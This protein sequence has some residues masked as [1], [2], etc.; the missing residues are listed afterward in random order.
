M[1]HMANWWWQKGMET[2]R[3]LWSSPT[4]IG[5]P[6][7]GRFKRTDLRNVKSNSINWPHQYLNFESSSIWSWW[8]QFG[9]SQSTMNC[10]SIC[11]SGVVQLQPNLL[12]QDDVKDYSAG[13]TR[14]ECS[15]DQPINTIKRNWVTWEIARSGGSWPLDW[16]PH[17]TRLS[18]LNLKLWCGWADQVP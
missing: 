4:R 2:R 15:L 3:R 17:T 6:S 5:G 14:I 10:I 12:Y 7:L 18:F 11:D 1:S 13:K 9:T 8:E 16:T